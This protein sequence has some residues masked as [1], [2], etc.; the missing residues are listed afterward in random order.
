MLPYFD[1][2]FGNLILNSHRRTGCSTPAVESARYRIAEI[3]NC[4]PSEVIFTSCGSESDNLAVR[5]AALA[6]R[7]QRGAQHI[8]ISP[9]E[10]PAISKTAEQLANHFGFEL[11]YLPVDDYGQI[12]AADVTS[13]LRS[14]TAVVSVIYANN[15]IGTIN[16]VNQI[17]E[18]CLPKRD[19]LSQRCRPGSRPPP[20]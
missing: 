16:P 10:H 9:V 6:A 18:I 8:L 1:Q 3:F 5:G 20:D 7:Q 19:P 11:E 4:K 15:E 17:G 14:D 2:D 12:S 13:R